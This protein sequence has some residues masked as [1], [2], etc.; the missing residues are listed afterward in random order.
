ML[1]QDCLDVGLKHENEANC[2]PI[3]KDHKQVGAVAST[4]TAR[5]SEVTPLNNAKAQLCYIV[6]RINKT[7]Q[8][9]V[10]YTFYGERALVPCVC[11]SIHSSNL[12][13]HILYTDTHHIHSLTCCRSVKAFQLPRG[14]RACRGIIEKETEKAK[15]ITPKERNQE[16]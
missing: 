1:S 16:T 15:Q 4:Q 14:Y 8:N 11:Y 6:M 5:V 9:N 13:T 7:V 10:K 2:F 12:D 3:I